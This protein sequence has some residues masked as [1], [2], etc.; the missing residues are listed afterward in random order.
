MGFMSS[1]VLYIRVYI[2]NIRFSDN[3]KKIL[4]HAS[5]IKILN[6]V[7][8][9]ILKFS[10]LSVVGKNYHCKHHTWQDIT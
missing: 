1:L 8:L 6:L 2:F 10:H 4:F 7:L 9:L 5:F 3:E